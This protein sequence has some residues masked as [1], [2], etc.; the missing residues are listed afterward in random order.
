M[1]ARLIRVILAAA[2]AHE[3]TGL[4]R[5]SSSTSTITWHQPWR[6]QLFDESARRAVEVAGHDELGA[7]DARQRA[8]CFAVAT[9]TGGFRQA[10]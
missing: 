1:S 5:I 4:E 6:R 10:T 2:Y 7:P 3:L 8:I 9:D